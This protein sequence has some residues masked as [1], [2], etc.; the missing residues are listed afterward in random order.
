MT[1]E[2]QRIAIAQACGWK[3]ENYGPVNYETLYWRLR[4]PDGTIC[5]NTIG[6]TGEDWSRKIFTHMVPNYLNDLNAMHEAEKVLVESQLLRYVRLLLPKD[7]GDPLSNG[8]VYALCFATAAQRAEAFL[9]T[10]NLW[11]NLPQ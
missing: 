4:R 9:R 8:D 5:E 7:A 10:L 3:I 1:P 11:Q 2:A 6:C